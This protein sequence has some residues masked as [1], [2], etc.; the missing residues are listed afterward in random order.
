MA[1]RRLGDKPLSEA[2]MLKLPTHICVIRP[3]RVNQC[4]FVVKVVLSLSLASIF[5]KKYLNPL[6]CSD[7]TLLKLLPHLPGVDECTMEPWNS[8]RGGFAIPGNCG[9]VIFWPGHYSDVTVNAIVSQ[10]TGSSIVY[11]NVCSD[12][13]KHQSSAS[14][15]FVREFTSNRWI[16]L[17]KGHWRGKC[18][19][20]MTSSWVGAAKTKWWEWPPRVSSD[21]DYYTDRHNSIFII[22]WYHACRSCTPRIFI[23]VD[24][25]KLIS[26]SMMQNI[27]LSNV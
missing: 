27:Y 19:L 8:H 22:D 12:Q 7:N 17:T 14:L 20:L 5:T 25:W 26:N 6:M 21:N 24:L 2:M 23:I 13:R 16:P 1:W 15:A 11:S 3:Q 9:L 4:C 18:Y 10:I